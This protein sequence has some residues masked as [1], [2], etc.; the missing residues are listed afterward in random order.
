MVDVAANLD[1]LRANIGAACRKAGRDPAG[2]RLVAVSK[3]HPVAAIEAAYRA[4]QRD[5]GENYAQ[6]L[7]DKARELPK[8]IH[9][10]FIGH[11]QSNKV[12]Y[13]VGTAAL[14]HSVDSA[15][16]L[17]G[18]AGRAKRMGLVQDVLVEINLSG[19]AS[20]TG[21][22]PEALAELASEAFSLEGVR[23]KGLMTM[24][25]EGAPP[26]AARRTFNE[27]KV[28]AKSLI[29][30]NQMPPELSM[31]M[32]G[33]FESAILEGATLVRIGTAIFGPREGT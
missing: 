4:G 12:K 21:A 1:R 11:L 28:L 2:V 6:E 15:E 13:V 9:W 18:V 8:D 16:I 25:A 32:S 5:F 24:A 31:G 19:E 20:K 14:V 22:A 29:L 10:H 26:E 27:L 30:P 23:L 7:R 3:K 17:E 33:D